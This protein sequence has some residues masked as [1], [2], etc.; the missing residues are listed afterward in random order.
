MAA[1]CRRRPVRSGGVAPGREPRR[2]ARV[3]SY[4]QMLARH[5]MRKANHELAALMRAKGAAAA[6]RPGG[7]Q[8]HQAASALAALKPSAEFDLGYV[9]VVGVEDHMASIALFEQARRD[10][11]DRDLAG[12]DR[13]DRCRCCAR[14]LDAAQ[15]LNGAPGGLKLAATRSRGRKRRMSLFLHARANTADRK[16][17]DA[18]LESRCGWAHPRRAAQQPARR[19]LWH[20]VTPSPHPPA[21]AWA[22]PSASKG[23]KASSQSS[24]AQ[25]ERA[26]AS[27]G[28]AASAAV[29]AARRSPAAARAASK[30]QRADPP[31]RTG[32]ANRR[33]PGRRTRPGIFVACRTAPTS[34][35]CRKQR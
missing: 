33:M 3:R 6:G 19:F 2:L 32:I 20:R 22:A 21:A 34:P 12:L 28:A 7:R 4:A 27:R 31:N 18:L 8:G 9:R 30:P 16:Q 11:R 35:W 5:G 15:K 1:R 23:G 26:S 25:S 13:Q 10:A 14:D 17:G 24:K 29:R